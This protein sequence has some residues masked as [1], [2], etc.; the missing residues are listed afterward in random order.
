M[1]N[2]GLSESIL[3]YRRFY[4]RLLYENYGLN[5]R[6]NLP[7]YIPMNS[8]GL[9]ESI[10]DYSRFCTRLLFEN[11]KLNDKPKNPIKHKIQQENKLKISCAICYEE[12]KPNDLIYVLE[13]GHNFCCGCLDRW[14]KFE[15]IE[16]SKKSNNIYGIC[17]KY[18]NQSI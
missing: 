7:D 6:I 8:Y 2:N 10:L 4:T 5:Y 14:I 13:C 17:E 1:N 3:D 16:K 18:Y 11:Y 9:S 15:N 12:Y